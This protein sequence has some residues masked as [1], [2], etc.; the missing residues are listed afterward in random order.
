MKINDLSFLV[1][2][3]AGAGITRAGYLLVK[4]AMRGGLSAFGTNDYGSLIRG[5]HNFYVASI[6]DGEV[7]SQSDYV[8][9]LFA[10]NAETVTL[11]KQEM[12]PGGGIIYDPSDL[13]DLSKQIGR[14]DLKLYSV[15]L[16]KIVKEDLKQ[17]P[18]SR[19]TV[20]LGVAVKLVDY[21][22]KVMQDVFR[23]TFSE[24]AAEASVKAAQAGYDFAKDNF[25][26][27]FEYRLEKVK[28]E[29]KYK[30]FLS[31]N[32]SI[33][34]G[35]ISAGCG[36]YVAYP[37]TPMTGLLTFMAE[38]ERDYKMIV[39]HP[40]GEIA[41]LLIAAGASFGGT[42][43]I[44][45]TSGGGFCL[46]SEGFGMT[47]MTET[48][49]VVAMGMRSG[50]STGLPTYTSQADLRFMLHASQ[51][52]FPRVVVA[53]GDVEECYYETMQA[54]NWADKYQLPV[55]VL[56]DKYLAECQMTVNPFDPERIGIDRGD[57]TITDRYNDKD[58]YARHRFTDTGI[59]PRLI[60][61]TIGAIVRTNSDEH[62]EYGHTSERP[63]NYIRMQ[64]K[65]QKKLE[66]MEREIEEKNI[67]TTRMFG[68]EKAEA[69]IIAWGS[70]KG[71]I[72]EAIRLLK[73][74]DIE[75]NYMQVVYLQ[76]FPTKKIE[77]VLNAARKT[78]V[79][80][81]NL[82]SQLSGLIRQGILKDVDQKILKYDGR[83]WNP[84]N[85]AQ[86]IKEVL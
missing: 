44:T 46:M 25:E 40:E 47:G 68:S 84:G 28:A 60:P 83:P 54:F 66:T 76:P 77:D 31:G 35:A 50:P 55:I 22:F 49:V 16:T 26:D 45:A 11:H 67:E 65:R 1:G 48:P 30:I 38:K 85:L 24:K 71:P 81:H 80:E 79:V 37:M 78:I 36:L 39:L 53:P 58:E 12:V 33:G 59:S 2:G 32:E 41:A 34:T 14:N 70:T 29:G 69:T 4:A 17:D 51:G 64:E 10:L 61:G 27:D 72:R 57:L 63:D 15:P 86:K 43:A 42:R 13:P 5:G 75:V 52:E 3:E 73:Q 6:R 21:D 9:L 23:D 82:T 74:D 8:D 56:V 20:T 19:N 62:D 18:I 7:Y